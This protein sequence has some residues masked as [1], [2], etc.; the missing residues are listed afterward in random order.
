MPSFSLSVP[1]NA[2]EPQRSRKISQDSA[3]RKSKSTPVK[4]IG[5]LQNSACFLSPII[6]A[7]SVFSHALSCQIHAQNC[8]FI[9]AFAFL[10]A[11][12]GI[13]NQGGAPCI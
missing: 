8:G 6:T 7:R 10:P 13:I 3:R 12:T 4:I 5:F 1:E 11:Y 9:L 2:A